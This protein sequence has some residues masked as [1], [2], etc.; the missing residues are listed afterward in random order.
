MWL[1]LACLKW[2]G[3]LPL[4]TKLYISFGWMTLFTV[5]LGGASL[6]GIHRIREESARPAVTTQ[7]ATAETIQI[8][9]SAT[10]NSVTEVALRFQSLIL[11]LLLFFVL[12]NFVMA[13]RLAH[14]ISSPIL[15][16][17]EV[18]ERLSNGDLTV[19]ANVESSDEAGRMCEALNRTIRHLH[20]VLDGLAKDSFSL[21]QVAEQLADHVAQSAEQCKHQSQLAQQVLESTR[22]AAEQEETVAR[23]SHSA[24][25]AGRASSK[26]AKTGSEIM[27]RAS[28]T[29]EI[30][31]V[32]SSKIQ[33]LM[34]E[35]DGRSRDIAKV[36]TTIREISDN[37]NLLALNASIEAA[38]AGEQG[39][40]FAVVAGEVRRLAEHTRTATEDIARTV[41]TIQHE[42][43]KTAGAVQQSQVSIEDGRMSTTEAYRMLAEIIEHAK[44]TE[45]LAA[46]T[47][48]A[49]K[50]QSTVSRTIANDASQVA[51]LASGSLKCSSEVAGTMRNIR[52]SARNLSEV[53]RQFKL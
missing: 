19:L 34:G 36:V 23:H 38:R 10:R 53:V 15:N 39:R 48:D 50:E 45:S 9:A 27:A 43:A 51:E 26:A 11:G 3:D 14:I 49:A 18:L 2:F 44:L 25:D 24:A 21:E 20:A 8:E 4:K 35:L 29:M 1:W 47:A 6:V 30:A 40:G 22:L 32:T 12:L 13:W 28:E 52:S 16:A 7:A 37:T 17:C 33:E 31:A 42:T 41:Q 5:T 46:A